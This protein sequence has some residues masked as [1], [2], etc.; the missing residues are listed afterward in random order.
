MKRLILQFFISLV[1]PLCVA[2]ASPIIERDPETLELPSIYDINGQEFNFQKLEGNV[3]VLH[4]WATWCSGCAKEMESLN[5]MQKKLKKEKIIIMPIS[6]DFKGDEIVR[7][8]Y[9]V[10]GL[11]NLAAFIDTKQRLFHSLDVISLPTTFILDSRGE[12]VAYAKGPVNWQ[13]EDVVSLLKKYIKNI[14]TDNRD[15]IKLIREQKVFAKRK[16]EDHHKKVED[17]VPVTS[18]TFLDVSEAPNKVTGEIK[19]TNSKG[20]KSLLKIRRPVN[21]N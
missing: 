1:L 19:V 6:E 16:E 17:L 14:N 20:E 13:D 3:L 2:H 4:F 12:L 7:K 18:Q 8:F 10:Y 15:Y 21:K 9:K 5:L 11:N